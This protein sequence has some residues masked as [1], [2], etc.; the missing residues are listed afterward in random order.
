VQQ[1]PPT[2]EG[3]YQKKTEESNGVLKMIDTLSSDI[4]KEM[5]VAKTEE[6][7]AQADYQETVADA[8]KKR[9]ADMALAASK[10]QD[11]ADL[12]GDLND[13]KKEN[14]GKKQ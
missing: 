1:P 14:A 10:A 2:F 13:D 4:E 6:E 8:A 9:E 3:G 12:E 7:N 11:K 5:A